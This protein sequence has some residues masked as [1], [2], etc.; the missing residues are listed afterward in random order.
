MV[1]SGHLPTNFLCKFYNLG[2]NGHERREEI[3]QIKI[4]NPNLTQ[5]TSHTI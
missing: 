4:F 5:K 2:D 3:S 1:G